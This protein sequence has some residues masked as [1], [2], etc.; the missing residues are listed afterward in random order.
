MDTT[1][2]K[3]LDR[4]YFDDVLNGC[5]LEVIDEI[6]AEN[7]V[8]HIPGMADMGR[9]GDK[10]LIGSMHASFPDLHFELRDQIAEGDR[11]L[12]VLIGRGTHRAEFMNIPATG[13]SIEVT[14]MNINRIANGKIAESWGVIDLLGLLQQLGVVPAPGGEPSTV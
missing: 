13:K 4:R 3:A 9:E 12:H 14:G 1:A 7:Y 6:C 5:K 2:I 8:S 10:Q 11:V